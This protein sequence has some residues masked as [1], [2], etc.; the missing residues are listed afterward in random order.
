MPL[1]QASS[2]VTRKLMKCINKTNNKQAPSGGHLPTLRRVVYF[3]KYRRVMRHQLPH[4]KRDIGYGVLFDT[5]I[6]SQRSNR[7]VYFLHEQLDVL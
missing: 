3:P 6:F 7:M 1:A 5:R 2:S 4:V